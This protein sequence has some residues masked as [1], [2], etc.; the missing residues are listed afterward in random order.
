MKILLPKPKN[1][2][3]ISVGWNSNPGCWVALEVIEPK[4]QTSFNG[5]LAISRLVFASTVLS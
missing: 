3:V 2:I 4:F 1:K 5:E